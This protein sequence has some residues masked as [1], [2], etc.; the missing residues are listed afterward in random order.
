MSA[1]LRIALHTEPGLLALDVGCHVIEL[2]WRDAALLSASL[3]ELVPRAATLAGHADEIVAV[4]GQA[5][6]QA[7][8]EIARSTP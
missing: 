8:A 4:L 5:F 2:D 1:S 7:R 6:E 3:V